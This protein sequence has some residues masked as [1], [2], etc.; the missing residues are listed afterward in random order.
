LTEVEKSMDINLKTQ[1]IEY[2]ER[3]TTEQRIGRIEEVLDHRTRHLTVVLEDVYQPHNASAVLRSCDCFGI[4]DVHIIENEN[5]FDPSTGVSLGS[6][7]WLT[8]HHYRQKEG[9]GNHTGRCF[10]QLREEGY[11]LVAMTPHH[12][13]LSISELPVRPRTAFLF[14]TELEGLSEFAMDH[15]DRFAG[16]PMYGFSGS[17]NISVS[18]AL[19]LYEMIPRLKSSDVDWQLSEEERLD[20]RLEWL[21][22]SI[23]AGEELTQKFLEE[24]SGG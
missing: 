13:E 24:H 6:D 11:T 12:D 20:L 21:Q 14:G 18:A 7:Q 10:K 15:A 1:L 17:F 2:L 8:L 19:T 22:Q 5:R 3:F 16:I 23:R 9:A 4:Q